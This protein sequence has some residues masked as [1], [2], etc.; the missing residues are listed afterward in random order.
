MNVK[1]ASFI[2]IWERVIGVLALFSVLFILWNLQWDMNDFVP[3]SFSIFIIFCIASVLYLLAPKVFFGIDLRSNIRAYLSSLLIHFCQITCYL[4]LASCLLPR[5]DLIKAAVLFLASSL[6]AFVPFSLSG[7]G[8][9]EAVFVMGG[10]YFDMNVEALV[11]ISLLFQVVHFS[12]AALGSFVNLD[13]DITS[14]Q[15]DDA[16]DLELKHQERAV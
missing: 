8:A 1:T 14:K 9:R 10:K 5:E 12:S 3:Q 2:V 16:Y 15:E 11:A 13:D 4:S 7:L 6:G